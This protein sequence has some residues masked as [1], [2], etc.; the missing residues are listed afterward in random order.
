MTTSLITDSINLHLLLYNDNKINSNS[1]ILNLSKSCNQ[2][3]GDLSKY[4]LYIKG[5]IITNLN[6]PICN[7][8]DNVT[9]KETGKMIYSITLY[10]ETGYNFILNPPS[11]YIIGIDGDGSNNYKGLCIFLRFISERPN[12]SINDPNYYKFNYVRSFLT[13]VNTALKSGFSRHSALLNSNASILFNP[14]EPY[15]FNIDN[16]I[17]ASSVGIYFNYFL[18]NILDGFNVSY[19]SDTDLS[20]PNYTGM[21]YL[22]NKINSPV[23]HIITTAP[24]A[25]YWQYVAEFQCVNTLSTY[26]GIAIL[27]GGSLES[28][29]PVVYDYFDS[30]SS[31]SPNL[32]TLKILKILDFYADNYNNSSSASNAVQYESLILD[33]PLNMLNNQGLQN[34]ALSFYLVASNGQFEPINLPSNACVKLNIIFKRVRNY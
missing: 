1:R 12:L 13:L 10:D 23:N 2:I 34:I 6:L 30:T 19:L 5:L 22:F 15:I 16:L 4:D 27:C 33:V 14:G 17:V 8:I 7:M 11:P 32:T 9:D 29:R 26:I 18:K 31:T 24:V 28:A 21:N 3:I 25:D 20:D